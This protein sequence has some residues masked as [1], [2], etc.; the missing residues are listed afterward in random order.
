MD[1]I[2]PAIAQPSQPSETWRSPLRGYHPQPPAQRPITMIARL[3]FP[4]VRA[5]CFLLV[6]VTSCGT[7]NPNTLAAPA[8]TSSALEE[9]QPPQTFLENLR[10][11]KTT[12]AYRQNI[13]LAWN[14]GRPSSQ[15]AL[16]VDLHN[17]VYLVIRDIPEHPL[18]KPLPVYFQNLIVSVPALR[19]GMDPDASILHSENPPVV[20]IVRVPDDA[21]E[22]FGADAI[23]QLLGEHVTPAG[24][25]FQAD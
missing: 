23:H 25:T 18:P 24:L 10:A 1:A 5:F 2:A 6:V 4:C 21:P 3:P 13:W 9:P 19:A 20:A 15:V 8:D 11:L 14:Q 17:Q 16:C 12:T 22:S 7:Q